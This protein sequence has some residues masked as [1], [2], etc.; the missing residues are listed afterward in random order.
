[1]KLYH[2]IES[3]L[4]PQVTRRLL[5]SVSLAGTMPVRVE[6]RCFITVP[7]EQYAATLGMLL[8]QE[9]YVS[10]LVYHMLVPRPMKMFYLAK[11][12][13]RYGLMG[14]FVPGP[15]NI[16]ISVAIQGG[17]FMTV[18]MRVTWVLSVM[19]VRKLMDS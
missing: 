19:M 1:M 3:C 5:P 16:W 10:N 8:T 12:Q 13:G 17:A 11:G 9:L 6:L 14:Y 18:G 7:G 2:Y 15:K 4:F